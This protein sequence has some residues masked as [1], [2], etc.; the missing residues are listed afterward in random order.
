[1]GENVSPVGEGVQITC[2]C[3]EIVLDMVQCF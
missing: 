2:S 3:R 1:M